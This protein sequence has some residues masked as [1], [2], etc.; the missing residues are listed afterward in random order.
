MLT[1]SYESLLET[2]D[3]LSSVDDVYLSTNDWGTV[4]YVS[5]NDY[6]HEYIYSE[7]ACDLSDWAILYHG[8][9]KFA[10]EDMI[11]KFDWYSSLDYMP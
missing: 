5:F 7:E 6:G 9:V 1:Y 3:L 11:V 2:L 10:D 8:L 4:L